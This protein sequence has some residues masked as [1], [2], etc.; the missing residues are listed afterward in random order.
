VTCAHLLMSM[1]GDFLENMAQVALVL[2]HF[3]DLP[4]DELVDVVECT[5]TLDTFSSGYDALVDA[6]HG[7]TRSA[8]PS[9]A[10]SDLSNRIFYIYCYVKY[11]LADF[12]A[13]FRTANIT[14][15]A[16]SPF[17]TLGAPDIDAL[18]VNFAK[19]RDG[20]VG[21]AAAE[22]INFK[23]LQH[24]Q[25]AAIL[26][27]QQ[28]IERG[29]HVFL[30]VGTGQG[31]SLII[32]LLA[33]HYASA[34]KRV[35][36]FTCYQH[37]AARDF[38]RFKPMFEDLSIPSCLVKNSNSECPTTARVIYSDMKTFYQAMQVHAQTAALGSAVSLD[39]VGGFYAETSADVCIL[40]EFDS[41]I[42]DHRQVCN[43]V[44]EYEALI[45]VEL[46]ERHLGSE[47]KFVT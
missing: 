35:F 40:D 31:K 29:R 19:K 6:I 11:P 15:L 1:G 26:A 23:C 28:Q 9:W 38:E 20:L 25:V 41:L 30:K 34:G 32:A 47:S 45:N 37:L 43:T 12:Q 24:N 21:R 3:C 13:W 5:N 16:N 8:P 10:T 36:I 17:A 33:A 14:Q 44:Y 42:M 18:F 2:G 39:D 22:K 46:K 7:V 4:E 27:S